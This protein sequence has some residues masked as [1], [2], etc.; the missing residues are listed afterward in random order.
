MNSSCLA[1]C[2]ALTG[3][4]ALPASSQEAALR[5]DVQSRVDHEYPGLFELYKYLH[6]HPELSFEEKN[7][8]ARVAEELRKAGYEVTTG[9]GKHGVVAVL[10]NG[11]GPT[12]LIRSDMDALPVKEQTGLPYASEVMTKD[13]EGHDVPVMHACGHDCH[14]ACLVGTARLL[15]S[16]HDQ[17]Q[18]TVVL[19]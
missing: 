4:I 15:K 10:R 6:S 11:P 3:L 9:V 8:S 7:T 18:G 16:L 13:S 14:M 5:N 19:I 1:L 12:V 2:A 17:W